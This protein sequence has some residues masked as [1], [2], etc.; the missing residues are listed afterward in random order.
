MRAVGKYRLAYEISLPSTVGRMHP[1]FHVSDLRPYLRSGNYQP[2]PLPDYIE[3]ELEYT[4]SH[5]VSHKEVKRGNV[6]SYRIAWDG[7]PDDH[8]DEPP[9]NLTNCP[10]GIREYWANLG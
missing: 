5:I 10:D 8:T 2:P 6:K 3:G 9:S 1:V 4:V 7:Y